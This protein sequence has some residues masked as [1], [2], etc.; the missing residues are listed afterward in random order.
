MGKLCPKG[1]AAAKRKFDVYP[2]A[3][4]NMYASAVCS[5]KIKPGGKKKTKKKKKKKKIYRAA[6]GGGLRKWVSEKWVDIGAPKNDG[7][8]QPCGR[9]NAKTSKRKYPKCVPLAKAKRM[10]A[11]Q[12]TSAVKRKRAKAQGVGGKPTFVKTFKKKTA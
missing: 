8:F 10:T 3:Y 2:S 6:T 4:A 5:G 1:K 12:R 9:K 11:G 7:K